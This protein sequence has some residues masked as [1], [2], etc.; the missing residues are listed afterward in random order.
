VP[1]VVRDDGTGTTVFLRVM[2]HVESGIRFDFVTLHRPAGAW[3]S[4]GAWEVSSRRST[5]TALPSALL[6]RELA[7]GGFADVRFFGDH[8]GRSFDA[9]QDESVIVTAV[10]R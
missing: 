1:P 9:A 4:G 2:D 7:A 10:R 3:E 5:H 8:S 6:E